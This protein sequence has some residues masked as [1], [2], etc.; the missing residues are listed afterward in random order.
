MDPHLLRT[1]VSVARCGS[2]SEA[3]HELG[4]TPSAVSRHIAT[5]EADLRTPLLT[6]QPVTLT[7][8][9]ARLL[10]HAG[11]LL[12]RL[13]A[14]RAEVERLAGAGA[15]R[16]TLGA[17][18][19]ALTPRTASALEQ[20]RKLHPGVRTT[21]R[22]LGR[23]EVPAAVARGALD[24]GLVDGP[25]APSDPLPPSAAGQL[26]AVAVAESPLVV[27]LPLGHPLARR[28]G[29]RLADLADS[30][31]LDAPDTAMPLVRLRALG[32]TGG[33][34]AAL[35]YQGTEVRGLLAL[36]AAG[37]GLTLV[38]HSATEGVPGIV[39]VPLIAPRV[40]HRIELLHGPAVD[41]PARSLAALVTGDRHRYG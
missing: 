13:D 39:A 3:A 23:Q 12:L 21:V 26:T 24:L 18:P 33:F 1:F 38:P 37:H 35:T 22:I 16:L 28:L 32:R 9:G 7:T 15:T 14:A 36:A 17:S 2:F 4:S 10:D 19:L 5:L 11:P 6:R 27:P 40:T 34:R 29:L 31:W 25:A 41:G 20:L 30:R 8:A